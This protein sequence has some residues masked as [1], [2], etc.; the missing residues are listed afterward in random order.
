MSRIRGKGHVYKLE[1]TKQHHGG[2]CLELLKRRWYGGESEDMTMESSLCPLARRQCLGRLC[3]SGA[4]G[5]GGRALT[6]EMLRSSQ[7]RD[8]EGSVQDR[9]QEYLLWR[10]KEE[11]IQK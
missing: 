3:G 10:V 6:Q 8:N 4:G 9:G 2:T 1:G 11:R 5:G 7:A